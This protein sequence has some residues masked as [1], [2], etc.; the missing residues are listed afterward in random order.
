M[1]LLNSS[2]IQDFSLTNNQNLLPSSVQTFF[3]TLDAPNLKQLYLSTCNIGAD[4][5]RSIVSFLTSPRSRN[6]ELLELNGNC[7]GVQGVKRI[8]DAIESS[9]FTIK[10]LGLLANDSQ[11]A[12]LEGEDPPF[13]RSTEERRAEDRA[14]SH[15]VHQRLPPLLERNRILT[16]RVRNA[17]Y[18]IISPARI[19]LNAR[20]LSPEESAKRI[21]S[22]VNL[23]S[24][25]PFRLLDLPEEV[26]HLIIRHCSYDVTAL[27]AGQFARVRADAEDR[28]SSAKVRQRLMERKGRGYEAMLGAE[29]EVREEWLKEGRWDKW[30]SD[31]PVLD[32]EEQDEPADGG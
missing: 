16:R 13:E 17:A 4:T 28:E 22:S 29:G 27:S 5:G 24:P 21:I 10:Q 1:D 18:R 30:E 20:P 7:L 15:H 9:N 23:G 8:V 32:H 26:I 31:R 14:L 12:V 19:I 3:R 25:P 2:S 11:P 6:L